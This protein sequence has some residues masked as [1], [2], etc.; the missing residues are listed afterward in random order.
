MIDKLKVYNACLRNI[1][2]R[3]QAI[4]EALD[5]AIAAGNEETKSSVG[6]KYETGRAM[7]QMEQDKQR[8]QLDKAMV[9]KNELLQIN[10]NKKYEKVER[11]VLVVADAGLY[12]ITT[13]IGKIIIDE[14]TVYAISMDAPLAKAFIGKKE[15]EIVFFQDKKYAIKKLL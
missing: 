13:G 10:L 7:M 15:N 9:L 6:D 3:I 5:A 4:Q 12:F 8:I 11:G 14:Y 1:E 2:K